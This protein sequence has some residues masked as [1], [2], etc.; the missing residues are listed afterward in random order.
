MRMFVSVHV[1]FHT[2]LGEL[3]AIPKCDIFICST[4]LIQKFKESRGPWPN[5][6]KEDF[7]IMINM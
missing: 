3:L 5:S 2:D 6:A 4:N 1:F 7:I